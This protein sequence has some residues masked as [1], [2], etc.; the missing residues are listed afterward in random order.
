MGDE[1]HIPFSGE[2]CTSSQNLHRQQVILAVVDH[3]EL[4][5]IVELRLDVHV[6]L[7][8]KD[9]RDER[10]RLESLTR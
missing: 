5:L 1:G 4:S 9:F 10:R 7:L 3:V 2:N 8:S 6:I